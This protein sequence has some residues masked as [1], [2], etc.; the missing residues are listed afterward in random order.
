MKDTLKLYW[1]MT[2]YIQLNL[3]NTLW[4]KV[5]SQG[6][7]DIH[8]LTYYQHLKIWKYRDGFQNVA[9]AQWMTLGDYSKSI[10]L[11]KM[12]LRGKRLLGM[13]TLRDA[14]RMIKMTTVR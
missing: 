1:K 11:I 9:E 3:G 10:Q 12:K 2:L 7:H 14:G 8:Y 13:S 4:W 5:M 6:R